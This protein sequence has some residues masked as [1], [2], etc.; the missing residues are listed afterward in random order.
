MRTTD[1]PHHPLWHPGNTLRFIL[2]ETAA[3]HLAIPG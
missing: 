1:N 2:A 3:R